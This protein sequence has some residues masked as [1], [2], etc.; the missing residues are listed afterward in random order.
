MCGLGRQNESNSAKE[1]ERDSIRINR[2]RCVV[3]AAMVCADAP[4]P[5]GAAAASPSAQPSARHPQLPRRLASIVT[6]LSISLWRTSITRRRAERRLPR[7]GTCRTARKRRRRF[8]SA[9]TATSRI[10]CRRPQTPL[11]FPGRMSSGAIP[12]VTTR[13]HSSFART[14]ISSRHFTSYKIVVPVVAQRTL[15]PLRVLT[16]INLC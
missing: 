1:S 6:D 14:V 12:P 5:A 4:M 10:L 16:R 7:T 2:H 13:T 11:P 8:R 3:A 15:S 9:A